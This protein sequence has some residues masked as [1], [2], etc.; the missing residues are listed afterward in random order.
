M[1]DGKAAGHVLGVFVFEQNRIVTYEGNVM[2]NPSFDRFNDKPP[3]RDRRERDF[4]RSDRRDDRFGSRPYRPYKEDRFS[5]RNDRFGGSRDR[6]DDRR[7]GYRDAN[8][9]DRRHGYGNSKDRFSRP[10]RRD[11]S[12][13]SGPRAR[14]FDRRRYTDHAA[15]VK[16][17]TV[18]LDPD[19]AE[20]FHSAQAVNE[21]LRGIL[22]LTKLVAG[23]KAPEP[24]EAQTQVEAKEVTAE[25][26]ALEEKADDT[27]AETETADTPQ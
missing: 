2:D 16:T 9:E 20:V 27:A 22:A 1:P 13:Q 7:D 12:G 8:P 17:A 11:F 25:S 23:E 26:S 21:A 14:A 5:D 15:F 6:F 4:S 3:R 19:V 18:R 24:Q 10:P